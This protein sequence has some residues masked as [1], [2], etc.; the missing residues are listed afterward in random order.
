[1][2]YSSTARGTLNYFSDQNTFKNTRN[3]H[4]MENE[5]ISINPRSIT[6]GLGIT[7]FF[8]ALASIGGQ[9]LSL[10]TDHNRVFGLIQLFKL[11]S[12]QNIPTFFSILLL[13][14]VALLLSLIVIL[15]KKQKDS[16]VIYWT[17][18]S[19]G[20]VIMALD[21]LASIHER[22]IEPFRNLLGG[23]E[24]GLLNY[25][26]VVPGIVLV[27]ILGLFFLKFFL[28]LPARSKLHFFI[29]AAVYLG[30]AIGFELIGGDYAESF[31][32]STLAYI[33]IENIEE[34][35]EMAGLIIFISAL[36]EYISSIYKEVRFHIGDFTKAPVAV[37][38]QDKS[39]R[40]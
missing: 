11:D 8:L 38:H 5:Q 24:L 3:S 7:T 28:R 40:Q 18:L 25:A 37:L 9:L 21:E 14:F 6:L 35:L 23:G 17:V 30:G 13:L 26:W 27:L 29:A 32:K 19:A 4:N 20:F 15:K 2:E 1:M 34:T 16:D 10:Y 36:F 22:L 12:E 31:G 39:S 33:F